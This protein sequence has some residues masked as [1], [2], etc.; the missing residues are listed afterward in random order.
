MNSTF[1]NDG[2]L[3]GL[4]NKDKSLPEFHVHVVEYEDGYF[5]GQRDSKKEGIQAPEFLELRVTYGSSGWQD[6][7]KLKPYL[8]V[9]LQ[10]SSF[11]EAV[12]QVIAKSVAR[13]LQTEVRWNHKDS[14]MG[15]YVSP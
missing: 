1:W 13:L 12:M 11:N 8:T 4:S 3:D 9:E 14:P 6:V 15:H 2:Y 5:W 7:C 10:F